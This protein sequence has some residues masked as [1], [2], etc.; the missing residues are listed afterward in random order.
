MVK[1]RATKRRRTNYGSVEIKSTGS[2]KKPVIKIVAKKRF[3]R[4]RRKFDKT[5]GKAKREI[6]RREFHK[7]MS[8][9]CVPQLN[10]SL[11]NH[12]GFSPI[13][14][15]R[16]LAH[17]YKTYTPSSYLINSF[18]VNDMYNPFNFSISY[19]Q[20]QGYD[21]LSTIYKKCMV[22]KASFIFKIVAANDVS[23]FL[24]D[25]VVWWDNT[26]VAN[27]RADTYFK[28]RARGLK[29]HIIPATYLNIQDNDTQN[30]AYDGPTPKPIKVTMDVRKNLIG[31]STN[32]ALFGAYNQQ[33]TGSSPSHLST[34]TF[35]CSYADGT[36]TSGLSFDTRLWMMT[37]TVYWDLKS[38]VEES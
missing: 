22:L 24:Q 32:P 29:M 1:R 11:G 9:T 23:E 14:R 8:S 30:T 25:I 31:E 6:T 17:S 13:K 19:V 10:Y 26:Q 20:A 3:R 36:A 5:S 35:Y 38:A 21:M 2:K 7:I 34:V 28:A 4:R 27:D 16:Q 33:D 18:H 15:C 37:D 12:S